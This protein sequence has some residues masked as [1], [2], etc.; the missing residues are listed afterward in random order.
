MMAA[1]EQDFQEIFETFQP[2]IR[3]YLARMVGEDEAEDLTQDVFIKISQSLSDFRNESQLSTWIYRIAANTAIDRLRSASFRANANR[4]D[5]DCSTG[6]DYQE[7]VVGD[8]LDGSLIRKEMNQ[9]ISGLIDRLPDD[10]RTAI[11]LSEIGGFQ[12]GE[13]AEMLGI[14][15]ETVKIRLHRARKQ[16]K[17]SMETNCTLYRDERNELACDRKIISLKLR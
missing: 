9:C 5:I 13:I 17:E 4:V 2:R 8:L 7:H 3:R 14:S 11:R 12:N 15:I 10:Y 1:T 6:D 16:L